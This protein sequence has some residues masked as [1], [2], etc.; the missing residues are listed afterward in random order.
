MVF[1]LDEFFRIYPTYLQT[2]FI[3]LRLDHRHLSS[4][5]SFTTRISD[6]SE[7]VHPIKRT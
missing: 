1:V 7:A 6:V 3:A 4:D 2:L 5:V